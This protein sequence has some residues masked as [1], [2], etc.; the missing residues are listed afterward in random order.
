M[1]NYKN[2]KIIRKKNNKTKKEI[3]QY[4]CISQKQYKLFES[5]EENIPI[6]Y[7]YK[8]C[9]LYKCCKYLFWVTKYE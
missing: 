1:I 4:L 2:L 7:I 9:K 3:S 8:L 6:E 5:G